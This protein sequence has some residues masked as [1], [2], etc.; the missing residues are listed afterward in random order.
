MNFAEKIIKNQPVVL[1]EIKNFE[2]LLF[3]KREDQI[4]PY[5]SGNKFRKLKYNILNARKQ[6]KKVLLTFGGAY[7]N[8]IS[9]VAF[10]GKELGFKTIGIIRGDELGHDQEN[11]LQKNLTLKAASDNGMRLKF[12]S[13]TAYRLKHTQEFIDDLCNEFGD[14]YLVPEG[15]TNDLAVRGCEEILKPGDKQFDI[16]CCSIGTGGTISGLINSAKANQKI[17]GFPALKGDFLRKEIEKYTIQDKN[18]S[19]NTDYHFGGFAKINEDL[20]NF[21]NRFKQETGIPLDPIY[22]GKM[23]FGIVDLINKGV[24]EKGTKILAIHTGGLQGIDGM[25]NRLKQKKLPL[26]MT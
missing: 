2:G 8:H 7:S 14:F 16:V 1:S 17:L 13:R 12:V 22:T 9:A 15:G 26:I 5:I 23:M 24:F 6:N 4:H 20:I 10:A 11:S 25:N 18:W 19:L 3:I 21:I